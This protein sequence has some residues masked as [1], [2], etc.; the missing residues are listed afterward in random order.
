MSHNKH[1]TDNATVRCQRN[2]TNNNNAPVS[3][4][5][6]Y[7]LHIAHTEKPRQADKTNNNTTNAKSTVVVPQRIWCT[8]A[9]SAI[10]VFCCIGDKCASSD[11]LHPQYNMYT[12]VS[13]YVKVQ[14]NAIYERVKLSPTPR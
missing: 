3:N 10:L 12:C 11:R 7:L 5:L 1:A 8:V 13:V 9:T 4:L 14:L 6:A 2:K